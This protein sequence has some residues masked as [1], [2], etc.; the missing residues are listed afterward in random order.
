MG[1]LT[2]CVNYDSLYGNP[3]SLY[4]SLMEIPPLSIDRWLEREDVI[5]V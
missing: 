4:D 5:A 2:V 3:D 1:T